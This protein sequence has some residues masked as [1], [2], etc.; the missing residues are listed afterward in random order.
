MTIEQF[1]STKWGA[2]EEEVFIIKFGER[3]FN[4]TF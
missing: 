1:N 4:P 2:P 3:I